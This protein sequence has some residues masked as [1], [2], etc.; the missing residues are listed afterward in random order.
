MDNRPKQI[1][2]I[3]RLKFKSEHDFEK[4]VQ[5]LRFSQN[6]AKYMES[7]QRSLGLQQPKMSYPM[8]T[9]PPEVNLCK[10]DLV[11]YLCSYE[12]KYYTKFSPTLDNRMK[13]IGEKTPRLPYYYEL[14]LK[15]SFGQAADLLVA[16]S[17][18]I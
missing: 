3:Y 14:F 12:P 8:I 1:S 6:I 7:F 5:T 16:E 4:A 10:E 11:I 13:E 18:D 15:G 9:T 2:V 17:E